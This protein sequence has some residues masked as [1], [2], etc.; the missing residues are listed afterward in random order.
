MAFNRVVLDKA[1]P[2]PSDVP[3]H[4]WWLGLNATMM[5]KVKFFN[6]P[7]IKYRRHGLNVSTSTGISNHNTLKKISDRFFLCV[8]LFIRY[9]R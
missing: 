3:M 8:N 4:D 2:F 5:G 9:I 7:L 1:L 6:K